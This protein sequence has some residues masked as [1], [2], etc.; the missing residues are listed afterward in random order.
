MT[1]T[2]DMALQASGSDQAKVLHKPRLLSDNGSSYISSELAEWVEDLQMDH[3][4]GVPFHPQTLGKIE[5]W[6]RPLKNRVLLENCCLPGDLKQ[7]VDASADHYNHRRNQESLQNF[8][9]ADGYFD[10]G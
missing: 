5:R 6:Q 1:D 7:Q 9:P 8:T 10:R 3:V 2:L 4:C